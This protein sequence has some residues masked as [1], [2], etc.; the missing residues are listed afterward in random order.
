M[1]KLPKCIV[2]TVIAL[3]SLTCLVLGA[4][5]AEH[6][7]NFVA[8]S[9]G[10]YLTDTNHD[11]HSTGRLWD[12]ITSEDEVRSKR[13]DPQWVEPVLQDLPL[14]VSNNRLS[15]ERIPDEGIPGYFAILVDA[16]PEN[17]RNAVDAGRILE[18]S[19]RHRLGLAILSRASFDATPYLADAR[20][21]ASEMGG[22]LPAP[23]DETG[24]VEKTSVDSTL[25][26]D[27]LKTLSSDSIAAS[28]IETF[29][30]VILEDRLEDLRKTASLDWTQGS[31]HQLFLN[32]ALGDY[33]G[34]LHYTD[35]SE[36]SISFRI[37]IEDVSAVLNLPLDKSQ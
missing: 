19:R 30:T 36:P 12:L 22:E 35:P 27:V 11:R 13:P 17:M 34:E 33:Q 8:R 21:R 6:R 14:L 24:P 32:R 25:S 7:T 5:F 28:M 1:I 9:L 37:T 29:T 16:V 4:G 3:T 18:G 26:E 20:R 15:S 23:L 2:Y 31:I 10:G